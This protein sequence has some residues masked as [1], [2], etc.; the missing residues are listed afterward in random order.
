MSADGTRLVAVI[1]SGRATG[2]IFTSTNSGATWISND[3]PN[4]D[5]VAVC[6]SAD[7]TRLAANAYNH[8]GTWTNSGLTWKQTS[9]PTDL[10]Y[11]SSIASSADGNTLL[12]GAGSTYLSTNS[13]KTWRTIPPP[14]GGEGCAMSADATILLVNGA[15][16]LS[17][18]G[19]ATWFVATNLQTEMR[20]AATS[21]DGMKLFAMGDAGVWASLNRGALWFQETNAPTSSYGS[22]ASSA[23]GTHLILARRFS[24]TPLLLS[25]DSGL[26]W[27]AAN[28]PTNYW[29]TVASSAD[30]N[31]LAAA[32]LGGGIWIGRNVPSPQLKVSST[33]SNV[34]LAWTVL[35]TNF[36]LQ[37]TP[38]LSASNWTARTGLS[39]LNLTNL[40]EQLTLAPT[41]TSSFLRL[42]SQ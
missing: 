22:I 18:N 13:G 25:N 28:A 23:D 35:S 33:G 7:G 26:T 29:C 40:E 36:V 15:P 31:T 2:P 8:G 12:A 17:T 3:A 24:S 38:D 41:N 21:V 19:G 6:S 42:I 14:P 39:T 37:Q 30:G 16:N 11:S 34:T 20:A 9:C 27:T 32:I 4:L 5:W 1:G 10:F